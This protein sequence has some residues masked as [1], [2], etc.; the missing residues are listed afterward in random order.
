MVLSDHYF[1]P[2]ILENISKDMLQGKPMPRLSKEQ[3]AQVRLQY[4]P[5]Y[6]RMKVILGGRSAPKQVRATSEKRGFWSRI[7]GR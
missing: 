3:E 5:E 6:E 2:D 4:L 7:F 1:K